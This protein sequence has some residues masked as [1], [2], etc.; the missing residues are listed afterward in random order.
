MRPTIIIWTI[1]II[2]FIVISRVSNSSTQ[3]DDKNY[4]TPNRSYVAGAP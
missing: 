1:A 2:L 4:D 3:E